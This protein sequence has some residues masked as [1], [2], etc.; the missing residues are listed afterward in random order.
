LTERTDFWVVLGCCAEPPELPLEGVD[1]AGFV[2][3][4]ELL[5]PVPGVVAVA[6]V[7]ADADAVGEVADIPDVPFGGAV[8]TDADGE[9]KESR[10]GPLSVFPDAV[11]P[12]GDALSGVLW[13]TAVA[14]MQ[15][16]T[17]ATA[18]VPASQSLR[19][20][21]VREVSGTQPFS[22][23]G[24]GG[25]WGV[26]SG[27]R[28]SSSGAKAAAGDVRVGWVKCEAMVDQE[29]H[30]LVESRGCGEPFQ[31]AVS[32]NIEHPRVARGSV[33]GILGFLPCRL[34]ASGRQLTLIW[35]YLG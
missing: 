24:R 17:V 26:V 29:V 8:V 7:D 16:T 10:P 31:L 27:M 28:V 9:A 22:Q 11:G 3:D 23:G 6:V 25:G 20:P 32:M 18:S 35:A 14:V 4:G 34:V 2:L 21:G 15:A 19:V 12:T 1:L 5:G 30:T 33:N 13:L